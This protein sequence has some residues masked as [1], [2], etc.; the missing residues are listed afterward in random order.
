MAFASGVSTEK[1]S[2]VLNV[3]VNGYLHVISLI[4]PSSTSTRPRLLFFLTT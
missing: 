2:K 3:D 1:S 4:V